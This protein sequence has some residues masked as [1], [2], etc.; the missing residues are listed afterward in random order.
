MW[1]IPA[2]IAWPVLYVE[3]RDAWTIPIKTDFVKA[4]KR[5]VCDTLPP[6]LLLQYAD[7]NAWCV[8]NCLQIYLAQL[9]TNIETHRQSGEAVPS[10]QFV[11]FLSLK[12]N[13]VPIMCMENSVDFFVTVAPT[14]FCSYP[15]L[16]CLYFVLLFLQG[17]GGGGRA[18]YA[19]QLRL[20]SHLSKSI[21]VCEV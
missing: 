3:T 10:G 8:G 16:C 14:H 5:F 2:K 20:A 9:N 1:A 15:Y 19:M 4:G 18:L 11:Q 21:H 17:G 6:D 12:L 7:E 13:F